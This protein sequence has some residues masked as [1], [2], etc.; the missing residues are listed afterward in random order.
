[1]SLL[2][3]NREI[4]KGASQRLKLSPARRFVMYWVHHVQQGVASLGE[5]TRNP[6]ASFMTM[7]V[8]GLSLTLPT[9]LYVLVKNTQSISAEWQQA[10]Q[11]TVF[12]RDGV[13]PAAVQTL[14][15]TLRLNKKIAAVEWV[16]KAAALQEFREKSGFGEALDALDSNPLP[17]VLLV[18]PA[19][20]FRSSEAAK[21]LLFELE[22]NPEVAYGKLDVQWLTRLHALLGLAQDILGGLALLLC[23]AVVLI[24]SNTIRLNILSKKDEIIV[25]KLVGATASFIQRPFLYTGMWYGFVG[26]VIAWCATS[27]LLWWIEGA[28]TRVT[29]LYQSQFNLAGLTLSEMLVVWA[30]AIGLGLLGSFLAVRRHIKMIEPS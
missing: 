5:L 14:Q 22:Q 19:Q 15:Q 18:T 29:D 7:A 20:Q 4:E 23:L 8:L 28:V 21:R 9:T 17:D 6:F 13:K 11:I 3:R 24:V 1:M 30:F 27:L 26:G 2:F 16:D 10:S 25:M 12:I